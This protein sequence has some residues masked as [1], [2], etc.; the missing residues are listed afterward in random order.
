MIEFLAIG[1]HAARRANLRKDDRILVVGA[2]PIGIGCMLFATQKD[3]SVT[4]LD[5]RQDRLDFCRKAVGVDRAVAAGPEVGE[6]LS[7]LTSGD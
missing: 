3:G 2:G 1:A 7:A 5:I 4:A 6:A